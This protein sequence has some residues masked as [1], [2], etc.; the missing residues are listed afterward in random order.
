[1][2]RPSEEGARKKWTPLNEG[3]SKTT[4]EAASFH[5]PSRSFKAKWDLGNRRECQMEDERN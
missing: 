4:S 1:L 5:G 2:L 3:K